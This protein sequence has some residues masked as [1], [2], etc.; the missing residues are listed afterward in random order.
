MT[1][2]SQR[3]PERVSSG[4]ERSPSCVLG[5]SCGE[6]HLTALV[7]EDIGTTEFSLINFTD[8]NCHI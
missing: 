6:V 2:E 1:L 8:Y 5:R 7:P 4:E 3:D